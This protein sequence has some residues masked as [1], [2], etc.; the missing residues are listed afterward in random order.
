MKK[1]HQK[2]VAL[3]LMYVHKGQVL[4]FAQNSR[5]DPTLDFLEMILKI[6][7]NE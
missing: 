3:I 2:T 1:K 5:P 7:I 4:N 6:D